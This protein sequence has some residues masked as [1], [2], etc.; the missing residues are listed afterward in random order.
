MLDL[1]FPLGTKTR[2]K[3]DSEFVF[4]VVARCGV[5]PVI[6]IEQVEAALP[7]ADALM[8]NGLPLVEITYRTAAAGEV[9]RLLR[10][11]RPELL[12]GAGTL[13]TQQNLQDAIS[14]GAKFG[15]APGLN[16]EIVQ[17]AQQANLPFIP[18]VATASEI[19]RGLSL[20]CSYLKFFPSEALG[21]RETVQALAGPYRHL[22]VRFLPTGGLNAEN[23]GGYLKV[24][25]V[26]AVG[27]TWLARPDDL[28]EGRWEMVAERCQRAV[29]IVA[30]VRAADH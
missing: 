20:G 24:P 9:I 18:G 29:E 27:G 3:M 21:G 13:V 6:A 19:E 8:E 30:Q 12:V 28:R 11:Q 1:P 26:A 23:L 2:W 5:V 17:S 22:G 7:L 15:V 25:E 4:G 16:P 10:E 14:A